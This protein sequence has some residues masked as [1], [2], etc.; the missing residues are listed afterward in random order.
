MVLPAAQSQLGEV[1][2]GHPLPRWV[3][4][5]NSCRGSLTLLFRLRCSRGEWGQAQGSVQLREAARGQGGGLRH[6]R[7]MMLRVAPCVRL[8]RHTQRLKRL[9]LGTN[10]GILEVPLC[11]TMEEE[12]VSTTQSPKLCSKLVTSGL[13]SSPVTS[14]TSPDM[15]E[16]GL[17]LIG[18]MRIDMV[19][20]QLRESLCFNQHIT[21]PRFWF[22]AQRHVLC[23]FVRFSAVRFRSPLDL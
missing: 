21:G 14:P 13:W 12:T 2:P 4:A 7:V 9:L 5:R 10:S 20:P 16:A 19:P 22:V 8:L 18:V 15:S 6:I 23:G 1:L 17:G 3:V 11:R